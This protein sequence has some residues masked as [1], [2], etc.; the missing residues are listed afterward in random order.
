MSLISILIDPDLEAM[1]L[2]DIKLVDPDWETMC[3]INILI[4]PD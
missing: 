4:D 3:L 1:S 2:I